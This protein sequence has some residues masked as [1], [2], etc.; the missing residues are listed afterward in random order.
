[1]PAGVSATSV[2]FVRSYFFN[3][4]Q[5]ELAR[6]KASGKAPAES[7]GASRPA[8]PGKGAEAE[9]LSKEEQRRLEQ[10][11]KTDSEVRQHEQMH[12]AVGRDLITSGPSYAYE[13]GPDGRNY[14]VSGEVGIDTSKAATPEKTVP[15]AQHIRATA[16]APADPSAQDLRVAAMAAQM[17]MAALQEIAQLRLTA[18]QEEGGDSGVEA[19]DAIGAAESKKSASGMVAYRRMMERDEV[20][21]MGMSAYA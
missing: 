2:G 11:K 1:M 18:R 19:S 17:E 20:V 13:K 4:G 21:A 10:L 8:E 9:A 5:D 15:K 3:Q 7:K 16:L 14:A 6:G 12:L